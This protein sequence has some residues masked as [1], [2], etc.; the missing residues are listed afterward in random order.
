MWPFLD[1]HS[2]AATP[3]HP[4]RQSYIALANLFHSMNAFQKLILLTCLQLCCPFLLPLSH[5]QIDY[6]SRRIEARMVCCCFCKGCLVWFFWGL[7]MAFPVLKI[8]P[9][10]LVFNKHLLNMWLEICPAFNHFLPPPLHL[11][12]YKPAS[13]CPSVTEIAFYLV[14]L[15]LFFASLSLISTQQS[16]RTH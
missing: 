4:P 9:G 10:I 16:E 15:L 8:V 5:F 14:S 12:W 7:S 1:T 11:L 3:T 6:N 2:K 13:S